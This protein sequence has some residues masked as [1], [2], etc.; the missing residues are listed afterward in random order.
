MSRYPFRAT[1]AKWQQHLAGAPHASRRRPTRRGPNTTCS[2]CSPIRRGASTWATCATTRWATWSRATSGRRASTCCIR[3]AGTRS[4]CRPRTRRWPRACIRPTG[5]TPTSPRCATQIKAMGLSLDW[6]REIATCDPAYYRHEQAMFLDFLERRP[7]LP[8]GELGQ[9]GSGRPDRARQR[10]GDRRPRLALG[11][12]GRAPQ[13]AAVVL[14]DH[15]LRRGAAG[16]A[17]RPGPLAGEGPADAGATGSARSDGR[18]RPLPDRSAATE[19]LEVFTTR[20][21]T[22][23][24]A[25]FMA[26]APDHPLSTELADEDPGVAAFVAEC[27][28]AAPARR[29]S[30][31][32]RSAATTPACAAA[33]RSMPDQELPVYVANFVLMDYG[34]GAIFGCPA[35]DQRDLEFARKYGLPVLPVVLP[36]GA[37][38]GA[39]RDRRRGLCRRRPAVQLR[40][41]RR[42]RRRRRQAAGDRGARAPRRRHAARSPSGCATGACR[43][44]ATGAARSR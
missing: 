12:R 32:R 24:G 2:R 7:G 37:D 29:R 22:L 30:R 19:P 15:R 40:L 8:Q 36:P 31:G 18:A 11:R 26:I 43:A 4:A 27:A 21:D 10:A 41:P 1:E 3:W 25:S 28:A 14:Q 13:A 44:S 6:S 9:L 38:A 17:G 5:P 34:T 33:I 39:L 35:H 16:R 20:P 42:P 23:F